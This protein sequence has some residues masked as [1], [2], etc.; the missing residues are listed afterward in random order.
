MGTPNDPLRE[1]PDS[2]LSPLVSFVREHEAE[3]LSAWVRALSERPAL[4]DV[5]ESILAARASPL[6]AS[7][8]RAD[9][10]LSALEAIGREL[11]L[12][13]FANGVDLADLVA[14]Y[15]LLRDILIFLWRTT[16]AAADPWP[17][18]GA[19]NRAI[20]AAVNAGLAVNTE[21]RLRALDTIQSLSLAVLENVTLDELLQRLLVAFHEIAPA[22]QTAAFYLNEDGLLRLHAY[23]GISDEEARGATVKVGEG[24]LGRIAF[25][26][27]PLSARVPS[28]EPVT[29]A[30]WEKMRAVHGLPLIVRGQLVGLAVMGSYTS[31]DFARGDQIAFDVVAKH[32]ASNI[33]DWKVHES[34]ED[35]KARLDAM[36]AQ[37]P[38][39]VILAE[40]PSGK[41]TL[42]NAQVEAIWRRPFI[43]CGGVA[44]YRAW[45]AFRRDG[46]RLEPQEFPL[47][48]GVAGAVVVNQE[49]EILRGDGTR[50]TIMCN[51]GPLR[52]PDGRLVGGVTT[53][54]D[55]TEK[56]RTERQVGWR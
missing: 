35:Q 6:L 41:M 20:D 10:D 53:F 45:P 28:A 55:I 25:E 42:H 32:A 50:G 51:A 5:P 1:G 30:P 31:W 19:I 9:T 47:A 43:A 40:A 14:H 44:E 22:V 8:G 48:H 16:A 15:S 34:I 7:L 46:R 29:P 56:R 12:A 38:A 27:R 26:K 13:E 54:V 11:A 52:A 23:F 2:A 49:I 17:G 33:Y 4:R 24:V 39:A 36:V 18:L 21:L 37:M 3:I